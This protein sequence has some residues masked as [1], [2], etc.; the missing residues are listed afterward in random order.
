MLLERNG[1][2]GILRGKMDKAYINRE[3]CD[4][5]NVMGGTGNGCEKN[6]E[7]CVILREDS[8]DMASEG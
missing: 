7:N 8:I 2:C 4:G 5:S 3:Y 1:V 6:E